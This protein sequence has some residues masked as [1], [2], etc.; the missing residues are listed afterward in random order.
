MREALDRIPQWTLVATCILIEGLLLLKSIALPLLLAFVLTA[1]CLTIWAK[2]FRGNTVARKP[3]LQQPDWPALGAGVAIFLSLICW[4]LT[5]TSNGS[6]PAF[7]LI[8]LVTLTSVRIGRVLRSRAEGGRGMS[9]VSLNQPSGLSQFREGCFLLIP[10]VLLLPLVKIDMGLFLIM[11][12]PIGFAAILA[13]GAGRSGGLLRSVAPAVTFLLLATVLWRNVLHPPVSAIRSAQNHLAR[14]VAFQRM[15][16][17]FGLSFPF[18]QTSLDR[19]AARAVVTRDRELAEELLIAAFPGNARD[20][21][22]PSIEQIWGAAAYAR[23]GPWG[24]GL[25]KAV[26]G[27]RGVAEAVSYAENTF[28]V[29]VLAEH[30]MVGGILVLLLYVILLGG[31]ATAVIGQSESAKANRAL[32]VVAGMVLTVPAAYVALSNLGAVPITGQN[33]PFLGLNSWADVALCAG[34]VGILVTGAIRTA[35]S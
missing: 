1:I 31:I 23:S 26:V 25:G 22:I 7:V 12:I 16:T 17:V 11:V 6:M 10:I 15:G 35:E 33:M 9:H 14:A 2:R 27:G 20:L 21:L 32:L 24:Q 30:G 29:F 18:V 19:A 4:S 34:A 5:K 28:S 13:R 8:I 3:T